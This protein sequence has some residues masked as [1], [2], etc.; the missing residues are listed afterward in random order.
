MVDQCSENTDDFCG[1][2]ALTVGKGGRARD[3]EREVSLYLPDRRRV[4]TDGED[5]AESAGRDEERQLMQTMR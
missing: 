3:S 2:E 1:D 5:V 4:E